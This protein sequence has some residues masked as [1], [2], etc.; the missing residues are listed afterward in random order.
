VST[1]IASLTKVKVS[2]A[3]AA[4]TVTLTPEAAALLKPQ[5]SVA[6][7]LSALMAAE[8]MTDAVGVMAR[9]LPKREAVWWACL[10]TRTLVDA[11]TPPAVVAAIEAAETWV[12][13]PSEETRRAA[14]DRAQATKFDHPGAWAAV[15]AFWSGGSMAPPNA[16]A[17]P[18]AEH[19]T[20]VAVAGAVNL[21]AVMRQPQYAKEKLKG[22]L[23]QAVDI[24]NGGNGRQRAAG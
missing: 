11:Q 6:D 3:E 16:P 14:M 18:P 17:V 5:A 10:A 12:Y 22:F 20:G 8:L 19:L 9:A 7:F 1:S 23:D 4:A 21:S 24:G 15:G 13:R 2:A